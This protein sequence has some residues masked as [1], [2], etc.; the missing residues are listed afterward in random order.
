MFTTEIHFRVEERLYSEDGRLCN[1]PLIFFLIGK[2]DGQIRYRITK[3]DD[4]YNYTWIEL[5]TK[6][7]RQKKKKKMK[8]L[9]FKGQ[10]NKILNK[11]K[12]L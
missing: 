4:E 2:I 5:G 6:L 9:N 8:K 12:I 7:N 3:T 11:K 10:L 1:H